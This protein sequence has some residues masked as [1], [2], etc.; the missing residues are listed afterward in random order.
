MAR[1]QP[2]NNEKAIQVLLGHGRDV[3]PAAVLY[4]LHTPV[5]QTKMTTASCLPERWWRGIMESGCK[6]IGFVRG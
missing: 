1:T 2:K 4:A 3:T 6:Q 5:K